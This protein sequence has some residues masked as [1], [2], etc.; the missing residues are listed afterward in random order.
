MPQRQMSVPEYRPGYDAPRTTAGEDELDRWRIAVELARIVTETPANWSVRI[1]VFGRWGEGKTSVLRFVEQQ[2]QRERHLIFWFNPSA[3][4]SWSELWAEFAGQFVEALK[5]AQ[6]NISEVRKVKWKLRFRKAQQPLEQLSGLSAVAKATI[7]P[8]FSLMRDALKVGSRQLTAILEQL[9]NRRV[10]VLI[11][12]LDRTDPKLVP[13]LLLA[14]RDILDL[15]G[16]AFVLAFDDKIVG[17]A[18]STYHPA[19]TEWQSFLDK[20]LDFRF[21]RPPT[22]DCDTRPAI[23]AWSTLRVC[24]FR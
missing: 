8:T 14:L 9:P 22:Y 5:V 12:D 18:L 6:I 11:D 3:M 16:F 1:G 15:P 19:W 17:T 24:A 23:A 2:L 10:V 21:S 13:Q 20:I 7:G 4:T